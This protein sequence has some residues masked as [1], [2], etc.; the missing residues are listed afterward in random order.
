MT[1]LLCRS[2][3]GSLVCF[4]AM[5][6][7]D[8]A[9]TEPCP[10]G[11]AHYRAA[12]RHIE[13]GGIGYSQGY[14]T[15]ETFLAP[16]PSQWMLMP[17]LDVR[18]HI[19]DSGKWAANAGVGVRGIL[20][21]RTYG[22]NTYYDY[23]NTKKEHYNQMG[24][25][26]ET[27][28]RSWDFRI[29]GYLPV[30]KKITSPYDTGFDQFSG[31]HMLLSQKY[32]FAMKGADAEVGFHFGKSRLF[33]FY[34]AAG[35]Y[36]YIGEIGDNTWGGK[37]RISGTFKDYITLEIRDSYDRMFHDNFQGQ[38][39]FTLPFGGKSRV[40]K[41]ESRSSCKMA[42]ALVS[43]MVQPVGREEIIVVGSDKKKVVATDPV[44]GEPLYFVF[45]DNTSHSDGTIESPYPTLA[46]AQANSK[47]GDTIYVFPGNGTSAGM[48]EGIT[49]QASQKLWG[50]GSTQF[51]QTGQG[52]IVIP[53]Q[54]SSSPVMTNTSG[55]GITLS[56]NN[57][58]SGMNL[59]A[60]AGSGI[61]GVDPGNA[62]ISSCTISNTVGAH[63][64]L[65][66]RASSGSVVLNN[67]DLTHGNTAVAIEVDN[68]IN[69]TISMSNC[70][71]L[72]NMSNAM[73]F[74]LNAASSVQFSF[75]NNTIIGNVGN[76]IW[77]NAGGTVDQCNLFLA[78]NTISDNMGSAV[79][80]FSSSSPFFTN[81]QVVLDGNVITNN[82][83]GVILDTP[84]TGITLTATDNIITSVLG[85]GNS[86]LF[87][88][89]SAI[90][91][92]TLFIANN[93]I[94]DNAGDGI[95]IACT[96]CSQLTLTITDNE[97]NDNQGSGIDQFT[98]PIIANETVTITNNTISGNQNIPN[99]NNAAGGIS[100]LG[101]NTLSFTITGNTVSNNASGYKN[102]NTYIG[103]IDSTGS[104]TVEVIVSNNTFDNS[105][106]A[107]DCEGSYAST[108]NSFEASNNTFSHSMGQSGLV[109]TIS[110]TGSSGAIT[111]TIKDNIAAN[112][113]L[114]GIDIL[115]NPSHLAYSI[116]LTVSSNTANNNSDL[117]IHLNIQNG[118][119]TAS[120]DNN[121][122]FSNT[123][124]PGFQA[125]TSAGS[126]C[127]EM[128]GNN[129]DTGYSLN[130]SGG[131]FKLAPCN[132]GAVNT[133]AFSFPGAPVTHVTSCPGA[134]PCE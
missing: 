101:F 30:G 6:F 58:I 43:R 124:S 39:T 118:D 97:I 11:K 111:T 126:L 92:A 1:S 133:G 91:T 52:V 128:S 55:D 127:L 68:A 89:S 25:G 37:G 103:A 109:L 15:I 17:F 29:N 84:C 86:G 70:N 32:Q 45:V 119:T 50:S 122:L 22:L 18:G 129:S 100:L 90:S 106:F 48:N 125:A 102:S 47:P 10:N 19:F 26:L 57:Q 94:N 16:D 13:G 4:T 98:Y 14:T 61:N 12:V 93:R 44:T 108:A 41:K 134:S 28:G 83:G 31:H 76:S 2:I 120:F 130:N 53:P 27:L 112:N 107:F 132:A 121:T 59:M 60:V 34:A 77:I 79:Y 73:F 114:T 42:D 8:N 78:N 116:P 72:S 38:L 3:A 51:T 104:N 87:I 110:P 49:L 74:P 96:P 40:K 75:T 131:I 46:L 21:Y 7:A 113:H 56:T 88:G 64:N 36:Y 20:G 115:V 82:V 5:A 69:A 54:S 66:Y 35:P 62:Q 81:F 99:I 123:T 65:A 71:I 33:D 63:I 85:A 9:S 24:V 117:G 23:R 95:T 80:V 67:L 105:N